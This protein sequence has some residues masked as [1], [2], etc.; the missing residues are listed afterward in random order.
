[1]PPIWASMLAE[2]NASPTCQQNGLTNGVGFVMSFGVF[3]S[4][5]LLAPFLQVTHGLSPLE[6]GI[7]TLPWPAMPMLIAPR[8]G[9]LSHRIGSRPLLESGPALQAGAGLAPGR[10]PLQAPAPGPRGG[11]VARGGARVPGTG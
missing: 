4:I 3:G 10:G 11:P 9:I 8:A 1:M 7:R 6:A 2:I 5:F